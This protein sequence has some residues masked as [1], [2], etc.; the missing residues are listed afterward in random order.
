VA[1]N[2]RHA[3]MEMGTPGAMRAE[4]NKLILDGVTTATTGLLSEY[5]DET[6]DS[7]TLER[8]SRFSMTTRR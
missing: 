5:S 8:S 2:A 4:S 3:S 6:E 7:N 1:K